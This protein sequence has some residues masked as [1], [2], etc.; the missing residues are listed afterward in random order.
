[1]FDDDNKGLNTLIEQVRTLHTLIQ[2]YKADKQQSRKPPNALSALRGYEALWL[3]LA[4]LCEAYNSLQRFDLDDL[5]INDDGVVDTNEDI[6]EAHYSFDRVPWSIIKN[7]SCIVSDRLNTIQEA[8][9]ILQ[10]L[11][12]MV[13]RVEGSRVA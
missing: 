8:H 1:M 9:S 3:R 13:E 5:E 2:D 4:E 11:T 10:A 6:Q 7:L 12:I